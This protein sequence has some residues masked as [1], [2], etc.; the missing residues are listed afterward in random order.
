MVAPPSWPRSWRAPL[1]TSSCW[2]S[3]VG[4]CSSCS[5]PNF[6]ATN[7]AHRHERHPSQRLPPATA[8]DPVGDPTQAIPEAQN[9][10]AGLTQVWLFLLPLARS[11]SVV[12]RQ[13][14]RCRVGGGLHWGSNPQGR[15]LDGGVGWGLQHLQVGGEPHLQGH[16]RTREGFP[17]AAFGPR[18]LPHV[19]LD[20]T[21]LLGRLGPTMQ[22]GSRAVLV[23]IGTSPI[24]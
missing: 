23:G 8:V 11:T 4:A 24:G 20:T 7:V 16:R 5:I 19:Y 15:R 21:Y 10:S 9:F 6:T 1:L 17:A 2:R 12:G 13:S 18:L 14:P 3:C 22:G